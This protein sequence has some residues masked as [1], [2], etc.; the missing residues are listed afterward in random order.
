MSFPGSSFSCFPPWRRQCRLPG[1][2]SR[3]L[4]LVDEALRLFESLGLDCR[5]ADTKK[6]NFDLERWLDGDRADGVL[7]F[8]N[9]II[10]RM[11]DTTS[12]TSMESNRSKNKIRR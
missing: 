8:E 2:A 7:L 6:G 3:K 1:R 9:L 10:F 12:L 4:K 11:P 5:D